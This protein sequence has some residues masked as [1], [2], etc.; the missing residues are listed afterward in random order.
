MGF[1]DGSS[2]RICSPPFALH[3]VVAEARAGGAQARDLGGK[4]AD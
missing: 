4:I 3:D 1:P 2:S